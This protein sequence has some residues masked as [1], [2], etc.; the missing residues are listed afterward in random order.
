MRVAINL[1]QILHEAPGGIGRYSAALARLLPEVAPG[2]VVVPFV[3]WHRRVAIVEAWRTWELATVAPPAPVV[4][5]LPRP[6]LYDAWHL[7]GVPTPWALAPALRDVD[8]VH[9]P[10]LAVPPTGDKP[11]VV[12]AHD[13]APLVMPEAF[14][15]RGRWFH[16]RGFDAL[17][18]RAA[19]VI[20]VSEAAKAEIEA[21]TR[22]DAARIRVVPNGVDLDRASDE[23]VADVRA[24]CGLDDVPYVLWAGVRQPRKNLPVLLDAFANLSAARAPNR[25]GPRL[26]LAGP[27]GWADDGSDARIDRLGD[28]V[29]VLGPV[30]PADLRA[31]Y[32]GAD[33]FTLPSRHEGFGLPLLEA[34][35]QGTPTI[36]ADIPALREVGG[37]VS[38]F[39]GV[40]D[41]DGWTR[42]IDGAL[43][44][45]TTVDRAAHSATA[46]ARA[47]EFSWRR[48]VE[49]TRGVYLE[50][51]SGS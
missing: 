9:A 50:A 25:P 49:R 11:L 33:V 1:E 18:R 36:A 28:R 21:H 37:E 32:A 2:D 45:G 8:L 16:R 29:R 34:M 41:V 31:L 15:R 17:E 38:T 39:V 24:R 27:H 19:L 6:V 47:A 12:T 44:S 43:Q 4:V 13:A 14:T 3:A 20:A 23:D 42:A 40:D 10:S 35:A 48:C 30:A 46:R 7:L 5:P 51:V 22:I 26:V